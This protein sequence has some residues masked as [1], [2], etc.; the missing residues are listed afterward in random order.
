VDDAGAGWKH[1]Q[2]F[3]RA[4]G[5]FE[6]AVALAVA[7][8]L[9]REVD[10]FGIRRGVRVDLQRVVHHEG[11]RHTG[12]DPLRLAAVARDFRAQRRKVQ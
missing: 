2:A 10:R 9:A 5:P 1:L 11:D 4:L 12:V 7:L 8:E 3:E 6:E